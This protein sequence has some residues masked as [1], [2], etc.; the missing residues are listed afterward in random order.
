MREK[1]A[2]FMYGRYGVDNFSKFLMVVSV[3]L[4][5]ISGIFGISILY[6]IAIVIMIY[7]YF[8]MFSKNIQRRY[9]ENTK[10]LNQKNRIKNI[11]THFKRDMNTRRTHHIY[12]CPNCRQRIKIPKGKGKISVRCPKCY[13]EFIKNS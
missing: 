1:L 11:F 13:T 2:R 8:R 12:S 10:Y 6:F 5:L 4:L 3:V 9:S 7:L